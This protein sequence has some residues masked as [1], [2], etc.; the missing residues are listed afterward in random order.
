[1]SG[2][3]LAYLSYVGLFLLVFGSGF[4]YRQRGKMGQTFQMAAI[5]VLIF[6]AAIIAYGF[7]DTLQ[8]QLFPSRASLTTAGGYELERQRDGHFYLTLDV[9]GQAVEFIVDTGASEIV[10][11]QR[12]ADKVGLDPDQFSRQ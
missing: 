7:K 4:L 1:M 2:D 8:S 5:W 12:D 11:T 6:V 3:D 9:N 10:L